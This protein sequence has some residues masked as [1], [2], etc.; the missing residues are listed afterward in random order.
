VKSKSQLL[1]VTLVLLAS[2][3]FPLV[4]A[5]QGPPPPDPTP[6]ADMMLLQA[7][8]QALIYVGVPILM[9]FGGILLQA[10]TKKLKGSL[11]A[12]QLAFAERVVHN[13]VLAAEQYNL[14]GLA[15]RSG[16]EKKAWVIEK[17][18]AFLARYGIYLDLDIL[19]DLV[20]A[21]V[22]SEL[23]APSWIPHQPEPAAEPVVPA[24]G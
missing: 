4:A 21:A 3:A 15:A 9:F 18:E 17:A 14:A 10:A 16:A 23:K 8:L 19:A 12:E 22:K 5:A 1:I 6:S 13:L 7:A 20:E 11:S 2:A 24:E